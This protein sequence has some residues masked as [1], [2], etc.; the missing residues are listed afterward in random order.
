[1]S[2][3]RRRHSEKFSFFP[4]RARSPS[5]KEKVCKTF[6]GGLI[7]P[8]ASN[9]YPLTNSVRYWMLP[10]DDGVA[11]TSCYLGVE[12]GRS[13]FEPLVR[14]NYEAACVVCCPAERFT[15]H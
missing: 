6:I 8:R 12:P 9:T 4:E 2:G 10:R 1:M 7:P 3:G 14:R 15:A 11:R 13:S 5:G